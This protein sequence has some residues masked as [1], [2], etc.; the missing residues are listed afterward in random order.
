MLNVYKN[1]NIKIKLKMNGSGNLHFR[2]VN[3]GFKNFET[4]EKEE[5]SDIN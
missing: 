5:I 4:I 3:C 2:Y 1:N